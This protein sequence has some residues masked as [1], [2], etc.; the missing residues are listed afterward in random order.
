M[1]LIMDGLIR[2]NKNTDAGHPL[3][4]SLSPKGRGDDRTERRDLASLLPAG[5]KDRM[6][7]RNALEHLLLGRIRRSDRTPT[8]PGRAVS[9]A[10]WLGGIRHVLRPAGPPAHAAVTVSAHD[11]RGGTRSL[12]RP[13]A[14]TRRVAKDG[15]TGTVKAVSARTVGKFSPLP[16]APRAGTSGGAEISSEEMGL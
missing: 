16:A 1:G 3:T 8:A 7:A 6:R 10:G 11:E 12:V 15:F 9:A 5:E 13:M 2:N 14:T 4:L